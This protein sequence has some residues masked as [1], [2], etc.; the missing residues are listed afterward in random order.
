MVTSIFKPLKI[1]KSGL[2]FDQAAKLGKA[3]RDAYNPGLWLIFKDLFKNWVAKG[4]ASDINDFKLKIVPMG[5]N[6]LFIITGVQTQNLFYWE[7]KA[8]PVYVS[9]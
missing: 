2:I 5:F 4:V 8:L 9:A 6:P 1:V 3:C 7:K